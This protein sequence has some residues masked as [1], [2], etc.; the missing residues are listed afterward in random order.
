MSYL[1]NDHNNIVEIVIEG[2]ITA[3]DFERVLP[4]VKDDLKRHGK[5]KILE[6]IRKLRRN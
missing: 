4:Q 3:E 2:K 1:S 5:I 6:E